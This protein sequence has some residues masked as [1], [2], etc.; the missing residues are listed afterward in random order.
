MPGHLSYITCQPRPVRTKWN[1]GL[2]MHMLQNVQQQ[3]VPGI[4]SAVL[5][6]PV[7]CCLQVCWGLPLLTVRGLQDQTLRAPAQGTY[8]AP[9]PL[10]DRLLC[11]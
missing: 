9:A 5:S 11:V 3:A 6:G 10:S 7:T 2:S 1:S 4:T 8:V